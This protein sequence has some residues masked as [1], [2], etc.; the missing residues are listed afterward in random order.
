MTAVKITLRPLASP[1]NDLPFSWPRHVR[2]YTKEQGGGTALSV[3]N[4]VSGFFTAIAAYFE[5]IC[6][7]KS[8]PDCF[9]SFWDGKQTAPAPVPAETPAPVD[10][11][12]PKI[13]DVPPQ[14]KQ[15]GPRYSTKRIAAGIL[16]ISALGILLW[17]TGA[18]NSAAE[19]LSSLLGTNPPAP[20]FQHVPP[21]NPTKPPVNPTKPPVNPTKPLAQCS[22]SRPDPSQIKLFTSYTKDNSERLAMS[23]KVMTN[24]MAYSAKHGYQ[25]EVFEQNLAAGFFDNNFLKPL[26]NQSTEPVTFKGKMSFSYGENKRPGVTGDT[27]I[28]A[29][30]LGERTATTRYSNQKGFEYWRKAKIGDI[31]EWVSD[32]GDSVK[33][34]V[35]KPLEKLVGSGK[36]ANQWSQ[37]EGWSTDY[38]NKVVRPKLDTAWQIEYEYIPDTYKNAINHSLPYWS[39]IAGINQLLDQSAG[40]DKTC[41]IVWL[42]DDAIVMN[43]KIQMEEFIQSHGGSDPDVHVIVT[44]DIPGSTDVNT[45]VLIVRNSEKSREFFKELW[46]MRHQPV[47]A[48]GQYTTYG[49]CPNQGCLHEQQAMQDLLRNDRWAGKKYQK[50]VN[51]IP[52]RSNG[53]GLNTFERFSH[54]DDNRFMYLNYDNDP[55]ESRCQSGDFICQ[56]T[57]L[58]TKGRRSWGDPPTNLRMECIDGLLAMSV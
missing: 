45:G 3:L 12:Q 37:L 33:V 8:F 14:E 17:K 22:A 58:A 16:G 32:N 10:L 42:D 57:G 9:R 40:D 51:I 7:N 30:A 25:Y 56:C 53:P 11:E 48:N 55:K 18:L 44:K 6:S 24:Q 36:T 1:A 43:S 5:S 29:V 20:Y 34:K 31:I 28:Q 50:A 27:T 54:L 26:S 35:T 38:F 13:D 47:Y 39:K 2:Q 49:S 41:W 4:Y 23:R 15:A 52:Q 19:S 21:V 46:E